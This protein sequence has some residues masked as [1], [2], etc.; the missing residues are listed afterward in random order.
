MAWKDHLKTHS[1]LCCCDTEG[2]LIVINAQLGSRD[3]VSKL[4]V[5][6]EPPEQR[7]PS[8]A[9]PISEGV[10]AELANDPVQ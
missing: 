5:L 2:D 10:A 4:D 6:V 1:V 8:R 3:F 9:R 7:D